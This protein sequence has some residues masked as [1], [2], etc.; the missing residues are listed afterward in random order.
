MGNWAINIQGVGSHHNK[1]L[2][3]DANRLS[4]KFVRE[5]KKA[6]HHIERADFTFGGKED[7]LDESV[8]HAG[9][10]EEQ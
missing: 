3:N 1:A 4:R 9:D 5:L 10:R 8:A 2:E 7:L 6:G